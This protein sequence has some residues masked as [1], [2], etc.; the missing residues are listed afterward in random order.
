MGEEIMSI[1]ITLA[2]SMSAALATSVTRKYYSEKSAGGFLS[3]L[4][5]SA[6]SSLLAALVLFIWGGVESLSVFTLGLGVLFGAIMTGQAVAMLKALEIGPMSYT[7]VIV[8]FSTLISALSGVAFFGE[9]IGGWQWIGIAFMLASFLLAVKEDKQEKSA[10]FR[11]LVFC[12]ITF[13]CT[14]GIGLMQKIHQTS[15]YKTEINSFLIVAFVSSC[16]GSCL[17]GLLAR[18][19][20][21][22]M[23]FERDEKGKIKWV[24]PAIALLS[25]SVTAVNH[26]LNLYLSGVMDSAVFFPIVNGGGLVLTTIAAVLLFKEKL[27]KRQWLGVAIGILS[28]LFLCLPS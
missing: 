2:V 25:G 15:A 24:L 26:K 21:K 27:T 8:S 14:G 18:R 17:I 13:L 3:T 20:E 5:F 10:S 9:S 19:K 28:V 1:P 4:V 16:L 7:T 11:W 12:V 22:T 6:G 23:F